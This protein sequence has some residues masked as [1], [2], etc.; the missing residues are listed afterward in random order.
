MDN[1]FLRF[2]EDL[3]SLVNNQLALWKLQG[4]KAFAQFLSASFALLFLFIFL[5]ITLI[6]VG[7]WL[8]FLASDWLDSFAWGF[9]LTAG[10]YVLIFG[11]LLAFRKA[12]LLHPLRN[13]IAGEILKNGPKPPS[14]V[15]KASRESGKAQSTT[16]K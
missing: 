10:A 8:G 2:F 13:L 14:S 7:L 3:K 12:L 5:N 11:L 16:L 9:G 6:L 4:I 1:L 15:E